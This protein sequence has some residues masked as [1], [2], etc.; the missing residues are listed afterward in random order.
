MTVC[1]GSLVTLLKLHWKFP[2]KPYYVILYPLFASRIL[3]NVVITS[4][5]EPVLL[6]VHNFCKE[7]LHLYIL[8][9]Q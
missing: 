2:Y 6:L 4:S 8:C 3:I 9:I 1:K 7:L 5:Q